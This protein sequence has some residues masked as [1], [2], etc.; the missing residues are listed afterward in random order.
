MRILIVEDE[1]NLAQAIKKGL[2][3]EGYA[4]DYITDGEKAERR[5]QMYKDEYDLIIM[6]LMLPNRSGFEICES[7]RK[8]GNKTPI[9]ILTARE[10]ES[11]KITGLNIGADDYLT[12]PFSFKELSARVRALMRRPRETL[13]PQLKVNNLTL[14]PTT[15]KVHKNGLEVPLT[16]K[17]YSLLEYLMRHPNQV[18]NREQ[19]LEHV[20]DF[21]YDSLSNVVDVHIKNL[22]KKLRDNHGETLQTVRGIGY[23]LKA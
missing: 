6:D 1:E 18:L 19:I 21:Y 5:L 20:W 11:D 8:M 12:K 17:E 4:A 13:P 22:R 2:E 15:R 9:I 23:Q 3:R 14:D 10:D 16:L 7:I